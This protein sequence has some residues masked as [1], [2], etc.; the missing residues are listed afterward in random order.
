MASSVVQA[1]SP[2]DDY[3]N[4]NLPLLPADPVQLVVYRKEADR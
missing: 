3:F 2:L 4:G 1:G